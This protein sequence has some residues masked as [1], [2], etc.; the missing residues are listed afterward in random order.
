[1][2]FTF[3]HTKG[4]PIRYFNI[5]MGKSF[6]AWLDGASEIFQFWNMDF[7]FWYTCQN[8]FYNACI[9]KFIMHQFLNYHF[10]YIKQDLK[11]LYNYCLSQLNLYTG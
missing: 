2:K 11:I 3:V 4:K 6:F 7:Q 9:N 1:M 8:K 10:F 5:S